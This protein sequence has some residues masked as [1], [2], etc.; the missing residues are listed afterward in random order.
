MHNSDLSTEDTG[1]GK[2]QAAEVQGNYC[3]C[4]EHFYF[5]EVLHF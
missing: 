2:V 5:D 1:A 4:K 3:F